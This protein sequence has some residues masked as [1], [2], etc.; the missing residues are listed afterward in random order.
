MKE[1]DRKMFNNNTKFTNMVC[2]SD[3]IISFGNIDISKFLFSGSNLSNALFNN[4]IWPKVNNRNAV[5]DE[6]LLNPKSTVNEYSDVAQVYRSLQI[7]YMN[8]LRYAEAGDFHVGEM[9]MMRKASRSFWYCISSD[10]YK[11]F[12]NYGEDFM[13]PLYWILGIIFVV[14][15]I[16]IY[17]INDIYWSWNPINSNLFK[18]YYWD[19]VIKN[20][21]FVIYDRSALKELSSSTWY[22][23]IVIIEIVFILTLF[24]L[25][26]LALRRRFKRKS[27]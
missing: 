8:Q 26:L 20:L 15:L 23:I 18:P 16:L 3:S 24:A 11:T 10:L 14:P 2:R 19:I 4:P 7:N 12:S 5:Y 13:R 25:F 9:E 22:S 27:F 6:I 17:S 1:S 21:S